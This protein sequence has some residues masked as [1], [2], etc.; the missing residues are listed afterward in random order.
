[1]RLGSKQWRGQANAHPLLWG[2]LTGE[3]SLVLPPCEPGD[4]LGDRGLAFIS[5]DCEGGVRVGEMTIEG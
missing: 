5:R 3:Y 4:N 1:M 2:R